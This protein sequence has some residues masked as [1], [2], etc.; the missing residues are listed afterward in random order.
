[1]SLAK[2]ALR[3]AQRTA[4]HENEFGR[5]VL[6]APDGAQCYRPHDEEPDQSFP[7]HMTWIRNGEVV[8]RL[9]IEDAPKYKPGPSREVIPP[10]VEDRP[11]EPDQSA[12]S[13]RPEVPKRGRGAATRGADATRTAAAGRYGEPGPLRAQR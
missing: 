12:Q 5:V 10:T 11:P 4:E 6:V 8:Y 2:A 1:M 3:A 13:T 9:I 7:V